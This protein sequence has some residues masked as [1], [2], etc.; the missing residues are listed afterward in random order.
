MTR[1]HAY[2]ASLV[3]G[4]AAFGWFVGVTFIAADGPTDASAALTYSDESYDSTIRAI[5]GT[6]S[7]QA[8]A[9]LSSYVSGVPAV[10]V[11]LSDNDVRSCGDLGRQIR[12]LRRRVVVE[13]PFFLIADGATDKEVSRLVRSERLQVITLKPLESGRLL[14]GVDPLP[15]PAVL[16][17][18]KY[19][20]SVRG[21]AHTKRYPFTRPRSFAQ[22]LAPLY[23]RYSRAPGQ[24]Q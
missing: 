12:E 13:V 23:E 2:S 18:D 24:P 1:H 22:E 8:R 5:E 15:R 19:L 6:L 3:A 4:A 20:L 9:Q 16:W 11:L 14:N 10:I 7:E 21:V 17:V